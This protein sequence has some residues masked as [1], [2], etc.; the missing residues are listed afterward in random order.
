MHTVLGHTLRECQGHHWHG[1]HRHV[2]GGDDDDEWYEWPVRIDTMHP[3]RPDFVPVK[4]VQSIQKEADMHHMCFADG[5][6][7][8]V[9]RT[10]DG[11]YD[12]DVTHEL[13]GEID[14]NPVCVDVHPLSEAMKDADLIESLVTMGRLQ[15]RW[16]HDEKVHYPAAFLLGSWVNKTKNELVV[17]TTDESWFF[18]NPRMHSTDDDDNDA[19]AVLWQ[20]LKALHT[21]RTRCGVD[22]YNVT[23]S[24]IWYNRR[25]HRIL[26]KSLYN[27]RRVDDTNV[28]QNAIRALGFDT[29][30]V[31][32]Q[33]ILQS[34]AKFQDD[35]QLRDL[36]MLPILTTQGRAKSSKATDED[37]EERQWRHNRDTLLCRGI[38]YEQNMEPSN[39]VTKDFHD[40]VN[41]KFELSPRAETAHDVAFIASLPGN[42]YLLR[43]RIL[44]LYVFVRILGATQTYD[45]DLFSSDPKMHFEFK[46][47]TNDILFSFAGA[48]TTYK[49][50]PILSLLRECG[51]M[52]HLAD[53]KIHGV[54]LEFLADLQEWRVQID[55]TRLVYT[56][57]VVPGLHTRIEH[58]GPRTL[59]FPVSIVHPAFHHTQ[60]LSVVGD[61]KPFLRPKDAKW[62]WNAHPWRAIHGLSPGFLPNLLDDSGGRY[63][64]QQRREILAVRNKFR[65]VEPVGWVRTEHLWKDPS[66]D[67]HYLVYA[68]AH[69]TTLLRVRDLSN[70]ESAAE[71][72]EHHDHPHHHHEDVEQVKV[73][74]TLQ[75]AQAWSRLDVFMHHRDEL[76]KIILRLVDD[77]VEADGQ[78]NKR[79]ESITWSNLIQNNH[80]FSF[81]AGYCDF[82]S[83]STRTL[84]SGPLETY[85]FCKI[86][87]NTD[88][89]QRIY[90]LESV[91]AHELCH[92]CRWII[93]GVRGDNEYGGHDERFFEWGRKI[94]AKYPRIPFLRAHDFEVHFRY[95]IRCDACR[96]ITGTQ[97][98]PTTSTCPKCG[99][100]SQ[101]S[102]IDAGPFGGSSPIR[103]AF[104]IF[105]DTD[106]KTYLN[107]TVADYMNTE[108]KM[109]KERISKETELGRNTIDLSGIE[110][111]DPWPAGAPGTLFYGHL[112]PSLIDEDVEGY[113]KRIFATKKILD[114]Y[115]DGK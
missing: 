96:V 38:I 67:Q 92:A 104:V 58:S 17:V 68:S 82:H 18:G 112:P 5:M 15:E 22:Y 53:V 85:R 66:G 72:E 71:F 99:I 8:S 101:V 9:K 12:A 113:S 37:D 83:R 30:D 73:V 47:K 69:N 4:H 25:A 94:T 34:D 52:E 98:A 1:I 2:H 13:H 20:V 41:A 62:L 59:Q 63:T 114:M 74:S 45:P 64:D 61:F 51:I 79:V 24:N 39:N 95:L 14:V 90:R 77:A 75:E 108:G 78:L 19:A 86:V 56:V 93:D 11:S 21:M 50:M 16:P 48:G 81:A 7:M 102:V 55:G 49:K 109:M 40:F 28:Y 46:G 65:F 103:E 84:A 87:L 31:A 29:T 97:F 26:F 107:N 89:V 76:S 100:D 91:L 10:A 32:V 106:D 70:A 57:P 80:P 35:G 27:R 33:N 111:G 6:K 44:E 110:I 42:H 23:P 54:F 36:V 3:L 60:E 105:K 43:V 115:H 88:F